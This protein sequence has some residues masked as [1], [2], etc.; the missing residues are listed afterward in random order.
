MPRPACSFLASRAQAAGPV[1][2]APPHGARPRPD[3][4]RAD[5]Y[6]PLGLPATSIRRGRSARSPILVRRT[7][8]YGPLS[9]TL[10]LMPGDDLPAAVDDRADRALVASMKLAVALGLNRDRDLVE[11]DSTT[12]GRIGL[13][14]MDRGEPA[15][16]HPGITPGPRAGLPTR[17]PN[18]GSRSPALRSSCRDGSRR[19]GPFR[20][21]G[22]SAS[23]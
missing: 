11:H 14:E 6:R 13:D 1:V 21:G 3:R 17:R 2:R 7:S 9:R 20:T 22:S 12:A 18:R 23:S 16:T 10:G 4:P 5:F 19:V 15:D 8:A